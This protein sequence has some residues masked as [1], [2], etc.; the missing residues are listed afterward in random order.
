M[1]LNPLL[2]WALL[3]LLISVARRIK[4][5]RINFGMKMYDYFNEVKQTFLFTL[6]FSVFISSLAILFG[7]VFTFEMLML[8]TIVTILLSITGSFHLLSPAYTLG[9]T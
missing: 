9:I 4:S 7:F 5:D 3:V 2:Y 8:L 6:I 1:F